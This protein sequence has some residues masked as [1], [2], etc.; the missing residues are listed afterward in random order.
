MDSGVSRL[1][2]RGRST[3]DA[4]G[5]KRKTMHIAVSKTQKNLRGDAAQYR[6]PMVSPPRAAP[7]ENKLTHANALNGTKRTPHRTADSPKAQCVERSRQRVCISV[8]SR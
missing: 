1:A 2:R 5:A 3:D 6:S 8:T 4:S 7:R